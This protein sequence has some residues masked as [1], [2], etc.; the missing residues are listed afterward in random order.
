MSE[1]VALRSATGG[2]DRRR[3]VVADDDDWIRERVCENLRGHGFRVT[4][5]KDGNAL[6]ALIDAWAAGVEE[7]SGLVISDLA[8]PGASGLQ[9]LGHLRKAGLETPFVLMSGYITDEEREQ[10]ERLKVTAVL[11]KPF[12]LGVL[13]RALTAVVDGAAGQA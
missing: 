10:A 2:T 13:R 12:D 7:T 5:L 8:M 3:I 11:D 9:A 4:A 1:A 6:C